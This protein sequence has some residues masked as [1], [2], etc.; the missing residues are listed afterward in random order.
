MAIYTGSS[1]PRGG[2]W[3]NNNHNTKVGSSNCICQ[4]CG[5][6]F[7]VERIVKEWTG[8]WVCDSL[9]NGCYEERNP[10]DFVRSLPEKMY[11]YPALP[12]PDTAFECYTDA[13]SGYATV[14][15]CVVGVWAAPP[16]DPLK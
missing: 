6:K 3:F 5:L 7:P 10:Q 16:L 12:D 1:T 9:A 2:K 11:V 13:I 15:C 14:G 8:L 4:R